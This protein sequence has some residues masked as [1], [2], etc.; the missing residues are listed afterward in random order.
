MRRHNDVVQRALWPIFSLLAGAE[1][2]AILKVGAD[3]WETKGTSRQSWDEAAD[4][5]HYKQAIEI[6]FKMVRSSFSRA[7]WRCGVSENA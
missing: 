7:L 3:V 1:N 2:P 6:P 5:S 4:Y